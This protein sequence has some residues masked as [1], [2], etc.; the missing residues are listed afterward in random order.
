[1]IEVETKWK[2]RGEKV[3]KTFKKASA[4]QD[5]HSVSLRLSANS[6]GRKRKRPI[7]SF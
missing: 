7:F 3:P 2:H 1:M 6:T 4:R 5:R